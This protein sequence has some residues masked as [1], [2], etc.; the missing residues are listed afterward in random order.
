[1]VPD[2]LCSVVNRRAPPAL[3]GAGWFVRLQTMVCLQ[4]L[5]LFHTNRRSL[6]D[7]LST[8]H[9]QTSPKIEPI[10]S[11][12]QSENRLWYKPGLPTMNL[13]PF[14][15]T[16][17]LLSAET[18]KRHLTHQIHRLR[19]N[20]SVRLRRLAVYL[21]QLAIQVRPPDSHRLEMASGS[22]RQG[23]QDHKAERFL[24]PPGSICKDVALQSNARTERRG[25]PSAS[26]LATDVDRPRSLQ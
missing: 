22:N 4:H 5:F 6:Q 17:I 15:P 21:A 16:K 19:A 9:S 1:M 12:N 7:R 25:R 13:Q 3:P 18:V 2:H 20:E 23:P 10:P 8:V 11:R 26:E 24:S 14:C